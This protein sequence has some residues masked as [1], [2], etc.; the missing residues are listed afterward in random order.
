MEAG[1]SERSSLMPEEYPRQSIMIQDEDREIRE[2]SYKC[3][4][5]MEV[6]M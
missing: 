3:V 6:E 2:V 5:K 4:G 1:Y